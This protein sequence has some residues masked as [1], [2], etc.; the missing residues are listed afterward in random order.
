MKLDKSYIDYVA[1]RPAHDNYSVNWDKINRE[2]GWEPLET[3]SS[4][5]Q[6]TISWYLENK[7]WWQP[8]KIEAENFYQKLNNYK[9]I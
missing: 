1:D 9:K 8:L 6:K 4:G 5:L 2:L 7:E 3:L